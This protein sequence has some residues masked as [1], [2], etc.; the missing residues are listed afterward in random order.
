M[1]NYYSFPKYFKINAILQKSTSII[2]QYLVYYEN[3][4]YIVFA[5]FIITKSCYIIISILIITK[6]ILIKLFIFYFTTSKIIN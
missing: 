1:Q 3:K 5:Y 6:V 4:F 2:F